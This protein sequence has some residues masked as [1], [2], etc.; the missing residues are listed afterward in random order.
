MKNIDFIIEFGK[1]IVIVGLSGSGKIM[2]F[3]L[4]ECFYELISGVIKL[5]EELIMSYLLELWW[6]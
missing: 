4:L 3:L 1:V 6:R 5:G 2:L